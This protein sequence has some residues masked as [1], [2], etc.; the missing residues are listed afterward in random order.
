MTDWRIPLY[1]VYTDD[2][3]VN[4]IT[5]IV[6]RGTYWAMGPEIQEFEGAIKNY[7]GCDYCLTLNS[8]T[9]A[10]HASLLAN[11][12]TTNDEII[13]PSFSFIS[14]ANSVLFVNAKPIFADIENTTYGLDPQSITKKISNKTKCIMPM[15]YGGLSCNITEIKNHKYYSDFS[16][17]NIIINIG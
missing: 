6:R 17:V 1:K 2:E 8:G 11:E 5:K 14:T 16:F 10:L 12:I 15:D 13:V 7:I 9:S 3:D 4:L